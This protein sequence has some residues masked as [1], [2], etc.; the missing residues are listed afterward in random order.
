MSRTTWSPVARALTEEG[1]K[2]EAKMARAD[3]AR[4]LKRL[5]GAMIWK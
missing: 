3:T 4:R 5:I 2:E 1:P